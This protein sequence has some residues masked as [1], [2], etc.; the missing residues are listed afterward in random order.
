MNLQTEAQNFLAKFYPEVPLTIPI[1]VNGRLTRVFGHFKYNPR[2]REPIKI[3]LAKRMFTKENQHLILGT[4]YHE[5]VHYA[6]FVKGAPYKD[7]HPYFER[8]LIR[9]DAPATRTQQYEDKSLMKVHAYHCTKCE[10][11]FN[12]R[13]KLSSGDSYGKLASTHRCPCSG[14]LRYMGFEE[15]VV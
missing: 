4:L 5:L 14:K 2:T 1:E 11:L 6:C 12:R 15:V 8:E 13:R 3:S 10:K 9:C 7:G